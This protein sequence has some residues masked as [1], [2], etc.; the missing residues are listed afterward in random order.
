LKININNKKNEKLLKYFLYLNIPQGHK[1]NEKQVA[2][3]KNSQNNIIGEIPDCYKLPCEEDGLVERLALLQRKN[4]NHNSKDSY[5]ANSLVS[6]KSKMNIENLQFL[7]PIYIEGQRINYIFN[8][9][10]QSKLFSY[11]NIEVIQKKAGL[12]LNKA[13]EAKNKFE[14]TI[15]TID[16]KIGKMIY[17]NVDK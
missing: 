10:Y 14:K 11:T 9:I 15:F 7:I 1:E 16:Y 2:P 5:L 4:E 6:I 3:K 17:G 8:S 12:I 13:D